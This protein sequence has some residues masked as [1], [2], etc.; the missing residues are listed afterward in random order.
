MPPQSCSNSVEVFCEQIDLR[1]R[2]ACM[3]CLLPVVQFE[4]AEVF[5]VG[6]EYV[7]VLVFIVFLWSDI[8]VVE[9]L[10]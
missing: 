3:C 6:T 7:I 1:Y 8:E 4:F 10:E 5:F 9:A 2:H